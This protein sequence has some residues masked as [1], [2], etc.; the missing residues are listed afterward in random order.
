MSKASLR[1]ALW[2]RSAAATLECPARRT[3]LMTR[4]AASGQSLPFAKADWGSAPSQP[5]R[6]VVEGHIPYPVEAVLDAPVPTGKAQQSPRIGI[7]GW[8][9]ANCIGHSHLGSPSRPAGALAD[10]PVADAA[11]LSPT[12]PGCPRRPFSSGSAKAHNS[13]PLQ[14]PMTPLYW[15]IRYLETVHQLHLSV[16]AIVQLPVHGVP[17]G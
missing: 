17:V 16:G 13:S 9:T 5:A 14:P 6:V 2:R 1:W 12:V 3:K 15:S 10:T 4:F 11:T 7:C 8:E